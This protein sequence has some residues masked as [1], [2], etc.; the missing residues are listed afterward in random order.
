MR[1]VVIVEGVRTATGSFGGSLSK[2]PAAV[3][4]GECVRA[5]IGRAHV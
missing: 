2:I 5:Q 4:G 1:D 3:H